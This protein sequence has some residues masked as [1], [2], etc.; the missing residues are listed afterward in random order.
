MLSFRICRDIYQ[1]LDGEGARLFGGHWNSPGLPMIYTSEHI[2]LCV[3]EQL[4]HLDPELMPENWVVVTI[5]IPDQLGETF[6]KLNEKEKIARKFGDKWLT[7]KRSLFLR[8]PSF[9]VS[10]EDNILLN[11]W[12]SQMA[13]VKVKDVS[14]FVFD[15]R[16]LKDKT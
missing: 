4:V 12:H 6:T 14:P 9:V 5:E 16:F 3:L 15:S 11:P 13:K 8:V 7:E 10:K 1:A 2:S